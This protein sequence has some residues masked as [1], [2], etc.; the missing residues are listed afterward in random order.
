MRFFALVRASSPGGFERLTTIFRK[1]Y[2]SRKCE[3]MLKKGQKW[4]LLCRFYEENAIDYNLIHPPKN[5]TYRAF[6]T[7]IC[8]PSL[9]LASPCICCNSTGFPLKKG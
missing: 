2:G 7:A 9:Q 8:K 3:S 4:V 6:V 5:I 1:E